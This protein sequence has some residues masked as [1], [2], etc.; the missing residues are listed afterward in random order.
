MAPL[1]HPI[2]AARHLFP[3]ELVDV[4]HAER[5]AAAARNATLRVYPRGGHNGILAWNRA[6]YG[7]DVTGF[8]RG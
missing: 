6:A 1:N 2:I 8:L 4:S 5:N 3:Y 7:E